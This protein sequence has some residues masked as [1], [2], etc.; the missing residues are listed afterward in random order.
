MNLSSRILQP[1]LALACAFTL[2]AICTGLADSLALAT[3]GATGQ[4]LL[5]WA[6]LLFVV[7]QGCHGA[8]EVSPKKLL[9]AALFVGL[10]GIFGPYLAPW[11]AAATA[12]PPRSV[13]TFVS[14]IFIVLVSGWP[15]AQMGAALATRMRACAGGGW[16]TLLLGSG[17]GVAVAVRFGL[18][19]I[20]F[21]LSLLLFYWVG[22]A[23]YKEPSS[24]TKVQPSRRTPGLRNH[25]PTF[26]ISF[27]GTL[28]L[29]YAMPYMELFDGSTSR[30]DFWRFWMLG[31]AAWLG[32]WTFGVAFAESRL[33]WFGA[34]FFSAA[35]AVSLA[36]MPATLERLSDPGTFEAFVRLGWLPSALD[37]MKTTD[38]ITPEG[39]LFAPAMG[40]RVFGL[41]TILL[42][43]AW[44]SALGGSHQLR[45]VSYDS[46]TATF[47][48]M[49]SA[50]L[51]LGFLGHPE[52]TIYRGFLAAGFAAAAAL[53]CFAAISSPKWR[54]AGFACAVLG[55]GAGFAF[56]GF[57]VTPQSS[58]PYF[59]TFDWKVMHEP[60]PVGEDETT[61]QPRRAERLGLLSV[62][63]AVE[64]NANPGLGREFLFQGRNQ[65]SPLPTEDIHLRHETMFACLLAANLDRVAM[66]GTPHAGSISELR[67][68]GAR[69]VHLAVDPP[70]LV[71]TALEFLP[72]WRGVQPDAL[73]ST[74]AEASGPFGLILLRDSSAWERRHNL[75]RPSLLRICRSQLTED[76]M[77]A[78]VVD[79]ERTLPGVVGSLA[80]TLQNNFEFVDL[81]L[82]PNSWRT[83]RILLTARQADLPQQFNSLIVQGLRSYDIHL[84]EDDLELM[85][86]A[87]QDELDKLPTVSLRPPL[88]RVVPYLAK[89]EFRQID[90]IRPQ[91]R[92]G[93]L[94]TS[95]HESL[96]DLANNSFLSFYAVHLSTQLMSIDDTYVLGRETDK[97]DLEEQ[98]LENL[99][100]FSRR[101]SDSAYLQKFWIQLS[102][103]LIAKRQPEW[104][105][106]YY[107][108]LIEELGWKDPAFYVVLGNAALEMLD[109][110]AALDYANTA[111]K[112][113]AEYPIALDLKARSLYEL[114]RWEEAAQAYSEIGALMGDPPLNMLRP[115][116]E[117][118]LFADDREA[119]EDIAGR[120]LVKSG[121]DSLGK[122]LAELLGLQL[123][124]DGLVHPEVRD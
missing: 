106:K 22:L 118:A 84:K 108:A 16:T 38:R 19:P 8:Y 50:L 60:F 12:G 117:A 100:E 9:L 66:I 6:I 51:L 31:V 111:T 62:S 17:L 44:R 119:A 61:Y 114:E 81:W 36:L 30:Q 39:D 99:L 95:M 13:S 64:R 45:S 21:I 74:I 34:G 4:V 25:T 11:L 56:T 18:G 28:G 52:L 46:L 41:S 104:S 115:W 69:E 2:G 85:R 87:A 47:W 53:A 72:A 79:A 59:D 112:T 73:Y 26:L 55:L 37:F 124:D 90:E 32:A 43:I 122:H 71:E 113:V 97:V 67:Q 49:G 89:T 33:R 86:V 10:L 83:P 98:T 78:V 48:G 120:L 105:E 77:V 102:D 88:S 42:A 101:H 29:L 91:L 75:Y 24:D 123:E 121:A 63:R 1:F 27:S 80:R 23:S 35:Y 109:P 7:G 15:L 5:S 82:L 96:G 93:S 54:I 92:A 68:I 40:F 70:E 14:I 103:L 58:Y 20:G 107:G 116:A 3:G 110:E 94:L 76:G 57:P 65:Q